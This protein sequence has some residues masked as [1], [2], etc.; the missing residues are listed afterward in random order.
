MG[1]ENLIIVALKVSMS[2]HRS[3]ICR[4]KELNSLRRMVS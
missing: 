4:A 3:F 2:S 1:I